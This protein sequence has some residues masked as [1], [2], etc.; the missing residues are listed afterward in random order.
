MQK[1]NYWTDK[2]DLHVDICPCDVH[3]NDWIEDQNIR[4]KVIYHFG[5][6]THHVI[7]QEQGTNGRGNTVFSITASIEEY[8]AYIKLVADQ[9]GISKHY[10]AYFGDI[11]L[12]NKALL[13][14][15][16]IVTMVHLCEFLFPNT[17][18]KEYGGFDDL[19]VLNLFT[20]KTKVGGH[21][22]FY[23]KSIG[24]EKAKP[25]IA[26]WEKERKVARVGEF[27]T[28]LIYQKKG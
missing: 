24:Y 17:A 26:K 12:S 11:Y 21:I 1:M 15:F 16:D 19:G 22:I 5:T 23:T 7:G 25:V 2:W 3:V 14:E 4:N 10:L 9:A 20:D 6:G 27:K 28:L 13:P 8:D 18:S